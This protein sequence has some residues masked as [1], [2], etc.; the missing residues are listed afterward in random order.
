M[1]GARGERLIVNWME[2][3]LVLARRLFTALVL[4]LI[5]TLCAC[6]NEDPTA[7]IPSMIPTG[8]TWKLKCV[9]LPANE[10]SCNEN[11]LGQPYTIRFEENGVVS[12]TNACNTCSGT[13]AYVSTTQLKIHWSCSDAPCGAPPPW[14][15]YG[16]DVANTTSFALVDDQLVLTVLIHGDEFIHVPSPLA[17]RGVSGAALLEMV[18]ERGE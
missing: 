9:R 7:P 8:V 16:A 11:G 4:G 5:G 2:V 17:A 12:G 14:I 3:V 1:S 18:H 15:G 6:G 10:H 13:Y